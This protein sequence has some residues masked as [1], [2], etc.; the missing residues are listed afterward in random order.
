MQNLTLVFT[1]FGNE[2]GRKISLIFFSKSVK[3][4]EKMAQFKKEKNN[5]HNFH[6][7]TN[8]KANQISYERTNQKAIIKL[9]D[10][11]C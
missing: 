3:C 8:Q 1:L 10:D 4:S 6:L 5:K 2:T 7:Q 11:H 9:L